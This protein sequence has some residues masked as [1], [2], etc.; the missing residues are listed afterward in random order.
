MTTNIQTNKQTI[1]KH[2][3]QFYTVYEHCFLECRTQHVSGLKTQINRHATTNS[4]KHIING[5]FTYENN[6]TYCGVWFCT[7]V[8]C[9]VCVC[10]RG[11]VRKG[12]SGELYDHKRLLFN[13]SIGIWSENLFISFRF[14]SFF[15]S[16]FFVVFFF[17]VSFFSLLFISFQFFFFKK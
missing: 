8:S 6:T 3:K 7:H 2:E 15:I 16:R 5:T 13:S 17:L 14:F 11:E 1:Q 9:G 4:T 10:G 12:G